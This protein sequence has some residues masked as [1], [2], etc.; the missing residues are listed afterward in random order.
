MPPSPR[1]FSRGNNSF[2][3]SGWMFAFLGLLAT[4]SY[5]AMPSMLLGDAFEP[6]IQGRGDRSLTGESIEGEIAVQGERQGTWE[7]RER[8]KKK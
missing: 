2:W 8:R 7:A 4:A 5:L 3:R 6:K 1:Q